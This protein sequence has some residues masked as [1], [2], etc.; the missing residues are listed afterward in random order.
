[1]S[2]GANPL[3]L[4]LSSRSTIA[5]SVFGVLLLIGGLLYLTARGELKGRR[6][7]RVPAAMR[8]G[9]SD[10][11]L[12]KSVIERYLL[13]GAI[14]ALFI[15]IWMPLYWLKEPS[16]LAGKAQFFQEREVREGGELYLATCATCHG[17]QAQGSPR[18]VFIDGKQYEYAEPPLKYIYS[19]Y[20]EAGRNED[21]ITQLIYDAINRGR[22]GTPMPTWGLAF[23]GPFN[24]AQV[25][26]LVLW[27][28]SIQEDFPK[29][30]GGKPGSALFAAN[31]AICHGR[32]AQ[33]AIGPNLQIAL[34]RLTRE[35]VAKAIREGRL[36]INRP[37]MPAWA[38]L[39]DEAIQKLV[40]FI[41][42]IQK[43]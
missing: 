42:S 34:Q 3:Y 14:T 21:D 10:A 9:A 24:I 16:R 37:S 13:V 35:Q 12:E 39:G 32:E 30:E 31:C 11:D 43:G 19:R 15:A 1:M 20:K 36:N 7:A 5:L 38:A 25:D 2:I 27:I 22:P 26:N 4:G 23:G 33:G 40:D 6:K 18:S 8:P 41:A 28:K 17:Q 29:A